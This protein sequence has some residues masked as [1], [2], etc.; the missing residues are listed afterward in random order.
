[1]INSSLAAEECFLIVDPADKLL[2]AARL[3]FNFTKIWYR[4]FS[5]RGNCWLVYL[6]I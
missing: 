4:Y 5:G 1:V 2:Y 6:R 3:F